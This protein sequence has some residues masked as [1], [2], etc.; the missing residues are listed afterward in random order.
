MPT[1]LFP[2]IFP[3]RYLFPALLIL[4]LGGCQTTGIEDVTGALGGKTE[5]AGKA[6]ARPE[7]D[8]LRERY[9]DHYSRQSSTGGDTQN[10]P[11]IQAK[12]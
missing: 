11:L 10:P 8:A 3:A 9:R 6:E 7:M 5:T 1:R 2:A 12:A 4:A